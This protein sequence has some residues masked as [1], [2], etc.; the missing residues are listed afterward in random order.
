LV[1]IPV[2][3][4]VE[5]AVPEIR[6]ALGELAPSGRA[7]E[8]PAPAPLLEELVISF[9]DARIDESG[10]RHR[11]AARFRIVHEPAQGV[12]S[13]SA[14]KDFESPLGPIE[15]EEIRWYLERYPG[16]PFGTFR[17][18][19]ERLEKNLSVWGREIYD[20]TLGLGGEQTSAWRRTKGV[21][22]RVVIEVDDQGE[23]IGAAALLA[24][25]WELI[26][27]EEG[28]LFEGGL[29]ARVVRRI[30][31]EVSK[32]ALPTADRLRVLLVI[33]RPEEE[34]VGFIDPR[35]SARS[36]I[37]A[38]APLGHRAELEVVEDGTF[39]AL[40][41]ALT[42]AEDEGRPFQVVHFDGH[43]IYDKTVGLGM[44]C[45]ENPADAEKNEL[46]RRMELVDAEKLGAL[47]RERRVPL[48]VLEACQTAMADEKATASVAARLLRAG[49][50]SV[51]AMTHAVLVE[52]ARRFVGRFYQELAAGERI[53][54]AMVA[55]EH[56][57]QDDSYRG[58]VGGHGELHLQDWFV[59][60][61]FQEEDGDLQL[62]EAGATADPEV[63]ANQ[64]AVREGDLP[65]A[66]AHGFVG[67]AHEL[68]MVQRLLKDKRCLTLLGEGGQ[69]KTA[70]A[71]ECARWLLDLRRFERVAFATVED[72]P[73]VRVL[74]DRL[75]RQ[76]VPDY[77]VA[78]AEGMG[79]NEE[80]LRQARLPVERVLAERRVLLVT[81]NLES[82]LPAPDQP[83]LPG[84]EEMLALLSDFAK[85][86]E[87]RL[88]L[89]SREVP[90][91]PLNGPAIRLDPLSK[92]EG[93]ELVAGVLARAGQAPAGNAEEGWIDELIERVG[94]HARS[95]VLL[96][97][98][99]AER[100]LKVTAESVTDILVELE[101]RH[102]GKRELSLLASVR[103]SLDRLPE[104]VRRQVRA[105]AVFHGTAH[106]WVLA[107]VLEVE[108]DEALAL[109]R[110]LVEIGLADAEGP[111][112]FP[113]PALGPAVADE[114]SDE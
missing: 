18:R 60:V 84:L 64:R 55:A 15:L 93:R 94:G 3:G 80:K 61:L 12:G 72:L 101:A 87:T 41:K 4:A 106:V 17:E 19:A 22:R 49:V 82:I 39:P 26:A 71:I 76:L 78:V 2:T 25:P 43:G 73:G 62:L 99:V 96:A 109:C 37:E 42:H 34:G 30:P 79:T 69:G 59:P 28:Y 13:R 81:D 74:L 95:L 58:E 35:A 114:L 9:T 50:G 1:F 38:L 56:H 77:S 103:L 68:L 75:G 53:G 51:L 16:W 6:R 46:K 90:P 52:T 23:G 11:A 83:A 44:L 24:L 5:D 92:L 91:A 113:D 111:Y 29:G 27:D 14:E 36:L 112:L 108:T 48:F 86:G 105:L 54:T 66:P 98:L 97:P 8:A 7:E 21:A 70:L 65:K 107:Q 102:P 85:I 89:T 104:P 67:R 20:R 32:E 63:L 33:A 88:L 31:R 110:G 57:L 10:G 40:R 47:L 45:F 100:G